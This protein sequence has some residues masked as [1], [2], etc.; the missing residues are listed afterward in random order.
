MFE[1]VKNNSL[2]TP[3]VNFVHNFLLKDRNLK[4]ILEDEILID[5]TH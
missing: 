5:F 4:R 2:S 3:F 1:N